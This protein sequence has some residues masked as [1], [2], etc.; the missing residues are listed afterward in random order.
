PAPPISVS[1]PPS[2]AKVLLPV[3]PVITLASA[4]PVPAT[5]PAPVSVRFS[6][7]PMACTASERLNAIDERT[8]SVPS[9]PVSS[10]M[11]PALSTT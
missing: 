6:M 3:L 8:R 11:S 2:P 10:T 1:A 5:L 9:P 7:S 4:L